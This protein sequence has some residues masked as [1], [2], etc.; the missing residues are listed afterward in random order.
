MQFF[1]DINTCWGMDVFCHFLSNDRSFFCMIENLNACQI[2]QRHNVLSV[3]L[4]C[5]CLDFY[6]N[7]CLSLCVCNPSPWALKMFVEKCKT[8]LGTRCV[9]ASHEWFP[10]F[11][12]Y[13][14]HI[15]LTKDSS[16]NVLS[17]NWWNK[18]HQSHQS[19]LSVGP[20][21]H[22]Q[23]DTDDNT[24]ASQR[25]KFYFFCFWPYAKHYFWRQNIR[26][27]CLEKRSIATS[28]KVICTKNKSSYWRQIKTI[29]FVA[30][31]WEMVKH[32]K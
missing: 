24:D 20:H 7:E 18:S 12:T 14:I 23:Q 3:W 29:V 27:T 16:S 11:S 28:D 30:T 4:L 8:W 26:L 21:T 25:S 32:K 19:V 17:I 31:Q 22:T 15:A 1:Y 6:A 5:R 10:S 2:Y 13:K 9:L